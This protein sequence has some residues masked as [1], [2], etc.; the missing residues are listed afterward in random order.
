MNIADA[1]TVD[2]NGN[3]LT[4]SGVIGGGGGLTKTG[5][6]TLTLGGNNAYTGSTVV[7]GGVLSISADANVG[8]AP[9]SATPNSIIL[10]GGYLLGNGSFTLNATRGIG[11]GPTT[12]SI[13]A[14]GLIDAAS[15]QTFEVDG[16]IASAGNGGVNSLTVNS[17]MGD[18]GTVVLGGANIFSGT[19]TISNGTLQLAN[20]LALQDS[21]LDYNSGSLTF[22]T[23]YG[24]DAGW[25]GRFAELPESDVC[26]I[27]R[28][29][30]QRWR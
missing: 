7:D 29:R 25:I 9:G 16:V 17:G 13:G 22:G 15:G 8:T 2:N 23:L 26:R 4:L 1:T 19:T 3:N 21:T 14:N 5:N 6:H 24:G 11:I 12:G 18:N 10:N 30:P 20:S 27:R 28:A